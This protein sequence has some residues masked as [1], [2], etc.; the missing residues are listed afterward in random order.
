MVCNYNRDFI[1]GILKPIFPLTVENDIII[2]NIIY[3]FVKY[4]RTHYFENQFSI[5]NVLFS[6]EISIL[7]L[8]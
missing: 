1:A 4:K 7:F 2:L 5:S 3:L 8:S 6:S